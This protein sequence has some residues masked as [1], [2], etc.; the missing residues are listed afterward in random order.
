MERIKDSLLFSDQEFADS[1]GL[2]LKEY[3]KFRQAVKMLPLNCVFEF[4]EKMNFHFEDLLA[5]D[6]K[7]NSLRI[8]E[9]DI[10]VPERYTY[11]TYSE[12]LPIRN[13]INYL[14]N[15][16]GL[17]AKTNLIRKFQLTEEFFNR[18]NQKANIFLISDITTY[19]KKTY[20]FTDAEFLAMGHRT[21][22]VVKGNFLRDKLTAPKSIEEVV[23]CFFEECT[24]LFD[25][26]YDYKIFSMHNGQAVIDATPIK[27]VIEELGVGMSEFSNEE[28]CLTRL[29][30]L[31]SI[32]WY[33]YGKNAPVTKIASVLDGDN[34]NR[35]LFD[36]N[37][38]FK[39][40]LT[41]LSSPSLLH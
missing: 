7:L 6:F 29:G 2:S 34:S 17:R 32:T 31:S 36:M 8:K 22:H 28:A 5:Q 38:F 33:K 13:I 11:A 3:L 20:N 10:P 19:L 27:H 21:P 14:E 35:Y 16:R 41:L 26:N 4:A 30:V 23:S 15:V 12:V 39:A 24:D 25:K 9:N 1:L 18:E 40:K 37:P